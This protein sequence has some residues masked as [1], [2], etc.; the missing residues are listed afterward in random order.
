MIKNGSR[1]S[2]ASVPLTEQ[3]VTNHVLFQAVFDLTFR[4]GGGRVVVRSVTARQS[5]RRRRVGT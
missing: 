1:K 3:F 4:G 5:T 2:R